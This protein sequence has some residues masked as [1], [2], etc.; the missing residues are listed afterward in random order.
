MSSPE[1]GRVSFEAHD[2]GY[3]TGRGA[4]LDTDGDSAMP[5][6]AALLG[7]LGVA[8]DGGCGADRG[9][10]LDADGDND[11]AGSAA[12]PPFTVPATRACGL[13]SLNLSD[14]QPHQLLSVAASASALALVR[15]L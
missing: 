10:R 1:R 2:G 8:S 14:P 13:S 12:P 5:G 4:R 9:T 3:G 6:P 11:M 7:D 15:A